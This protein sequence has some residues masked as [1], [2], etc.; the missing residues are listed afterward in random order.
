MDSK[1]EEV[2]EFFLENPNRGQCHLSEISNNIENLLVV[3]RHIITLLLLAKVQ[4]KLP[5]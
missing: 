3:H 5:Y 1:M 2:P 4:Y